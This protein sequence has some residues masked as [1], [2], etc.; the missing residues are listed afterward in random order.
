MKS[1]RVLATALERFGFNP[2]L[3]HVGFVVDNVA[4]AQVLSQYF[5]F[6]LSE[7]FHQ[8]S[9][10]FMNEPNAVYSKEID[11]VVQ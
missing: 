8:S 3:V 10:F 2:R 9:C 11:S 1:S 4:L 5:G 6:S 7:S